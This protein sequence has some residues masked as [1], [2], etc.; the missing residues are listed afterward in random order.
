MKIKE[1][2]YWQNTIKKAGSNIPFYCIPE[3]LDDLSEI[4]KMAEGQSKRVKAVG[5]GH[6]FSDVALPVHYLVDLKKLDNLLVLDPE[7]I[8]PAYRN[9]N[10]INVE[11]GMTIQKFNRLMDK[12]GLCIKNMGGID[13]QTLAGAISTGTHGT[14]IDLPSLPGMVHSMV[15]VSSNG[16]KYRVEPTDGVTD[17]AKYNEPEIELIQDD[18][19]FKS[20]MV[21][22]GCFGIIYSFILE[23]EN[24]YYLRESKE[25]LSWTDVKPR[26]IDKSLFFEEDGVTPIRGMMFQINPYKVNNDHSCIVVKHRLLSGKPKRDLND[27]KRNVWSSVGGSFP[28]GIFAFWLVKK[29]A[30]N[31]PEK[32]VNIL[33]SALKRLKD[34][35]YENEGYKVLYQG[36]EYLK[37]RAYDS[38]FAFDLG[39]DSTAY[40]DALEEMFELAEKNQARNWYQTSPMGI[41]FVD[42]SAAYLSPEYDKKVAYID[43][44]FLLGT[45]HSDDIL[46]SYQEIMYKHGGIPHWGKINTI[47]NDHK[48]QIKDLYPMLGEWEKVF[49][50]FNPKGTF[51]NQFTD[52]LGLGNLTG[53]DLPA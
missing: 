30:R 18:H 8:K 22:L 29:R 7:K 40:I 48:D 44:P 46:K 41:R 36:V 21:S 42:R 20:C 38:E 37:V 32:F 27:S 5:S 25:L 47:L 2:K 35:R 4:I 10:L 16:K 45:P 1:D 43:A 28:F 34:K 33:D 14:G 24:M 39:N 11:G 50:K 9:R 26:L 19:H 51:N 31:N 15:L 3:S 12:K 13:N 53:G 23:M 52:R 6:S 17:P 49:R